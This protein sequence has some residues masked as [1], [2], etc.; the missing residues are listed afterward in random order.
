MQHTLLSEDYISIF[1]DKKYLQVSF[2]SKKS[3]IIGKN[4]FLGIRYTFGFFCLEYYTTNTIPQL[5]KFSGVRLVIWSP[6]EDMGVP[7]PWIKTPIK[8][9]A[10]S[11]AILDIRDLSNHYK[12]WNETFR[13]A[14]HRWVTQ[15]EYRIIEVSYER[16][17]M[18]YSLYSKTEKLVSRR[19]FWLERYYTFCKN[20][21]F[22]YVL[23]E[24]ASG[25]S[26]AGIATADFFSVNQAYYISAF[27]RKDIAPSQ[28]GLW[29]L[30]NWMDISSKKNLNFANLGAVWTKGQPKEWKGFTEFKKKFKPLYISTE[31]PLF[32][33]TFF[34]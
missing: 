31:R 19:L 23:Q 18:L 29:L 4:S 25:E 33:I 22:F 1:Q 14:Y 26:V 20:D 11:Y 3:S 28:A 5:E 32:R 7:E 9:T 21:T 12:S 13:N 27:T 10:I 6:L 16:Y 34:S 15:T 30:K 17:K 8:T 2:P 24:K